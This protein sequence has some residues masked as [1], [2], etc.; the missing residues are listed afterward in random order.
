MPKWK[1]INDTKL[2]KEKQLEDSWSKIDTEPKIHE[3][4]A[5][6]GLQVLFDP[7]TATLLHFLNQ[8]QKKGK[9]TKKMC[10]LLETEG[11]KRT[12]IS[13]WPM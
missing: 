4:T 7:N 10:S 5:D 8:H 9:T 1:K 11:S 13:M 12:M 6:T 3:F 2:R